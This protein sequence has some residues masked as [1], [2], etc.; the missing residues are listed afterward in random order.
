MFPPSAPSPSPYRT[1]TT[2]AASHNRPPSSLSSPAATSHMGFLVKAAWDAFRNCG[3]ITTWHRIVWFSHNIPRHAFIL[4]LIMRNSLKTQDKLRQWDVWT[5]IRHLAGMDTVPS[6]IE[7]IVSYLQPIAHQ[8]M[9]FSVIGRLL[10]ATSAYYIW[11]E[12]N[13]RVFKQAKRSWTDIRDIIITTCF[14]YFVFVFA[15]DQRKAPTEG[16]ELLRNFASTMNRLKGKGDAD[17]SHSRMSSRVAQ[18]PISGSICLKVYEEL[19]NPNARTNS[20][21]SKNPN[22]GSLSSSK[23]VLNEEGTKGSKPICEVLNLAGT[24]TVRVSNYPTV[25]NNLNVHTHNI[26]N[27]DASNVHNI[28][29]VAKLFGVP[30]NTLKDIDDFVQELQLGKHEIIP[31]GAPIVDDYISTKASPNTDDNLSS[32]DSPSDPIMQSVDNNTKS[33]S[34]IGAAGASAM[35]QPQVNFKLSPLVADLIFNSVNISIP[36]KVVKKVGL[37]AILESGPWI[38]PNTLI[39]LKKLSMSTSLLKEE[40]TRIPICVKLHDVPLQV[41]KEDGRSSFARCLIEVNSEADLVDSVTI[42]ILSLSGDDFTKET[43]RVE[44]E[45]RPPMCDVCKIFGHVH[46]HC[47]KKVVTPNALKKGATNLSNPSTSSY[48]LKIAETSSKQDN[49]TTSNSF[50][51][52]NDDEEDEEEVENVYDEL[53]NLFKTDGSSSFMAPAGP[54][55]SEV[56]SQYTDT[57]VI[58]M[59]LSLVTGEHSEGKPALAFSTP[60]GISLGGSPIRH[61]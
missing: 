5:S 53:A 47:P 14:D 43:I 28:D 45:W 46:D 21:V 16:V 3:S 12:H 1:S 44:Y 54:S 61:P 18:N 42:G 31:K 20:R 33:T 17:V 22:S 15:M 25:F 39:I 57:P 11:D 30:L 26:R 29:D 24:S 55:N 49:F 41:F 23:A 13:K 50:F 6:R 58:D 2:F 40:L 52:L 56:G 19:P 8:R 59:D 51:A 36:Q 32:K 34:Y 7:D 38:V 27:M 10:L 9:V 48:V 37:E 4:W 60:T 35:A